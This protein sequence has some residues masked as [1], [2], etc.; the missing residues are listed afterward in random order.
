MR[1]PRQPSGCRVTLVAAMIERGASHSA[2]GT[3]LG[4]FGML[5]ADRGLRLP[6][7]AIAV[8]PV[9]I[10]PHRARAHPAVRMTGHRRFYPEC[11]NHVLKFFGW[12]RSVCVLGSAYRARVRTQSETVSQRGRRWLRG[13]GAGRR[14]GRHRAQCPAG[15]G[16]GRQHRPGR[17]NRPGQ[18]DRVLPGRAPGTC[19]S[20]RRRH[21]R[22]APARAPRTGGCPVPAAAPVAQPRPLRSLDCAIEVALG[23]PVTQSR[24]RG[25]PGGR[26]ILH[27]VRPTGPAAHRETHSAT[28][29]RVACC[30]LGDNS[31]WRRFAGH[32]GLTPPSVPG[33]GRALEAERPTDCA[34][35]PRYR[36]PRIVSAAPAPVQLVPGHARPPPLEQI[37]ES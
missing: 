6:A 15:A 26:D 17:A 31:K 21:H 16:T 5:V 36:A 11:L 34:C 37:R 28:T 4:A 24:S 27:A 25:A 14:P 10:I 8:S 32:C 1:Q 12:D 23:H 2:G 20:H 19:D 22:P 13:R 35:A 7:G 33:G 29:S 30:S 3:S 9:D 18:T